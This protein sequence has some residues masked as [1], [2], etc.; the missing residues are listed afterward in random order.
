MRKSLAF[1]IACIF[2]ASTANAT[3]LEP[4]FGNVLEFEFRS[5]YTFQS[6]SDVDTISENLSVDSNDH[7]L[8]LSLALTPTYDFNVEGE[9][10]LAHTDYQTF[11][12]A[13]G[14][15]TGRYLWWNDVVGDP[16]SVVTGLSVTVPSGTSRRDLS[17]P[18]HGDVELEVHAAMGKECSEGRYWTKRGWGLLALGVANKGSPWVRGAFFLEKNSRNDHFWKLFTEG[19]WGLGHEALDL[20]EPFYSYGDIDHRSVDVGVGYGWRIRYWGILYC[21]YSYRVY[22][23]S[24]PERTHL[25]SLMLLYPFGC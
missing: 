17:T 23:C 25:F 16:V 9:L 20:S 15:L 19:R 13:H 12:I 10:L 6:Y 4:W 8:N 1:I 5:T 2:L 7:F 18:Y 24:Y 22:A 11:G 3:Q 14:R 21:Q